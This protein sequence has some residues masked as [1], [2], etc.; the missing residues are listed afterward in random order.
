MANLYD[1]LAWR[2][3]LSFA[4][5]PPN[6]VD[7]LILSWLSYVAWDDILPGPEAAASLTLAEAARRYF[8]L[9]PAPIG[10]NDAF[11]INVRISG[12]ALLER[13][14]AQP[15]YRS[16]ALCAYANEWDAARQKQFAALTFLSGDAAIVACRGTDNTIVGW[17]EDCFLSLSEAVPAQLAA[18]RYLENAA[19]LAGRPLYLCGHSKGGNLAVYAAARCS[20]TIAPR[21]QCVYNFDGPGFPLSFIESPDY[22]R[23]LPRIRTI[24][25]KSSVV[26]LLLEHREKHQI[27]K[28]ANVSVL[29]H[30]AVYWEVL[31]PGF[32]RENELSHS[33]VL[34]DKTLKDWLQQL[35]DEE[36]RHYIR[37]LFSLLE[38]TGA[39]RIE[40]LSAD[41]LGNL[42]RALRALSDLQSVEKSMLLRAVFLLLRAGNQALYETVFH[43]DSGLLR[44]GQQIFRS[45][46]D[47]IRDGAN[48]ILALE[49]EHEEKPRG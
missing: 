26:G 11:S 9:H 16:L 38:A 27:V 1:Y 29:Q 22:I 25:P 31:G 43:P 45:L 3:D 15:R 7:F 12:P 20:A 49:E 17:K 8:L 34:L 28:S 19:V 36:K 21:I 40:E 5:S 6:E 42:L 14:A 41:G 32:V 24:I 35:N 4:Q 13:A 30:N 48:D 39:Q 44:Q 47:K 37:I 23:L 33:S 18:V 46:V 2:G 10:K